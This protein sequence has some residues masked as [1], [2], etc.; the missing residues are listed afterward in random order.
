MIA[1][2]L[3][4]ARARGVT[5]TGPALLAIA[6]SAPLAVVG[7]TH[8]SSA[9]AG[10]VGR[11]LVLVCIVVAV[12]LVGSGLA[13]ADPEL[14]AS[15]P[16]TGPRL[17]L[18][19]LTVAFLAVCSALT[20]GGAVLPTDVFGTVASRSAFVVRDTAALLGLQAAAAAAV[21]ARHSWIPPTVWVLPLLPGVTDHHNWR[22]ALLAPVLGPHDSRAAWT[23]ALLLVFGFSAYAA[24][25][26]VR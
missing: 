4:H 11:N 8:L 2:A 23:A 22:S 26:V 7:L 15:T 24:R 6:V 9:G 16:R 5:T 12:A 21:G 10:T 3:L 13:G 1:G 17:R 14:E 20:L 18:T 25:R 19:H